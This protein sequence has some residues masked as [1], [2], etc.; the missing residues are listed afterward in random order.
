[1]QLDAKYSVVI[2]SLWVFLL[3]SVGGCGSFW[4]IGW[5]LI[6]V[7]S[8]L[9]KLQLT[10]IFN[11]DFHPIGGGGGVALLTHF[12]QNCIGEFNKTK[13]NNLIKSHF[14][15]VRPNFVSSASGNNNNKKQN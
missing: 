2:I 9:E 3:I 14:H 4:V 8:T 11:I 5:F 6:L 1:M 10:L 13:Y 12:E 15:K 7:L